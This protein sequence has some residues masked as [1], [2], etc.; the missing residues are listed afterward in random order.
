MKPQTPD[1]EVARL[2]E[3][4]KEAKK[5][6]LMMVG[7]AS[8]HAERANKYLAENQKLR[9]RIAELESGWDEEAARRGDK[10]AAHW[11]ER[12][13]KAEAEVKQLN[14]ILENTRDS[15]A[16]I[17][18]LRNILDQELE[19]STAEVERL[20][21]QLNRAVE[22]AEGLEKYGIYE[23]TDDLRELKKELK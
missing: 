5:A 9:E 20:R 16:D 14:N 12:A 23:L 4:L 6:C 11:K 17:I 10:M 21:S 7:N 22:I 15:R 1:N 19:E 13:E 18:E 2:R 3:E 8:T